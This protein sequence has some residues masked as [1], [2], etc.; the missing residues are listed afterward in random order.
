MKTD[1]AAR[2]AFSETSGDLPHSNINEDDERARRKEEKRAR[3]AAMNA[4]L[5]IPEDGE[6]MQDE[7]AQRRSEKRARKAA[8]EVDAEEHCEDV[9]AEDE[10]MRR[11]LEKKARKAMLQNNEEF[12]MEERG[13]IQEEKLRRK[14][15]M[16]PGTGSDVNT[17]HEERLGEDVD[18]EV[19]SKKRKN[20]LEVK[21]SLGGLVDVKDEG[22]DDEDDRRKKKEE[23]RAR[24]LD[25][26]ALEAEVEHVTEA[27][28]S[29]N[30]TEFK[31]A[32]ANT[33]VE[34]ATD[35]PM[36]RIKSVKDCSTKVGPADVVDAR[37]CGLGHGNKR[38]QPWSQFKDVRKE[39]VFGRLVPASVD[40]MVQM[41]FAAPTVIQAYCW[42][43]ACAGRDLIGIAKTGSGK[44][45][46]YL[47]PAFPRIL[48][49][50]VG[51]RASSG[52]Y[53][54]TPSVVVL[55][56]TRELAVQIEQEA[57]RF[58]S[59]CGIVTVC[60]YGG[61]SK[62]DQI[63]ALG[64]G[65]DIIVAT[66]GRLNDFLAKPDKFTGKTI[67]TLSAVG[68][69]VLDEADRMLDMGFEPQIRTILKHIPGNRQTLLFSATWP[70]EVR[71]LAAEF[72]SNP[73][74]VSV[75]SC[76][77]FQA[78][79]DVEQRVCLLECDS[80]GS[81]DRGA[82]KAELRRILKNHQSEMCIVFCAMK[83]TAAV[84]ADELWADGFS[85]I[86]LHGDLAQWQRDEAMSSFTRGDCKILVATDVA[87]RGLDVQGITFVVNYDPADQ[88]D[89]H[90]HR[91]GRTGRAGKKGVAYTLLG[92]A[93]VRQAKLVADVIR[94]AGQT[95]PNDLAALERMPTGN[96]K[97]RKSAEWRNRTR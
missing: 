67:I 24:K 54:A 20:K 48:A 55:A 9:D 13:K 70:P 75:G 18:L 5:E 76:D 26:A 41:G 49:S 87:A 11:K 7:R 29:S 52:F 6:E 64:R 1:R 80:T 63:N 17:M 71:D 12:A 34:A 8:L 2:N 31:E 85:A 51:A 78:N 66:A 62:T 77:H 73:L 33:G 58:Q 35:S 57:S 95:V 89:D 46:A 88:V 65:S 39:S 92:K 81:A 93:E 15:T 25:A 94:K 59:T 19:E 83:K 91:T 3:K 53:K 44:T 42:P 14:S 82:K 22:A 50:K 86:G 45:L 23:R 30:D 79:A 60:V 97:T 32:V 27:H 4:D 61:A 68:Y 72:I 43:I 56:P 28:A 74:H 90:V 40:V 37:V 36:Q 47:L 84:L 38:F 69:V 21:A 96:W 16:E 10:R